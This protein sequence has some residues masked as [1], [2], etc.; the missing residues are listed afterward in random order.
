MMKVFFVCFIC[1]MIGY[2]T[3]MIVNVLLY[4]P[5]DCDGE[6]VMHGDELYLAITEKDKEA[7]ESKSIAKLKLVRKDFKGFNG[8]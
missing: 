2:I 8:N 5:Y 4:K 3:A 6:I 7:L 1:F